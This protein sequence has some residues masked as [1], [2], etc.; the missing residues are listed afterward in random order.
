LKWPRKRK[1]LSLSEAAQASG[2]QGKGSAALLEASN[3]EKRR[4]NLARGGWERKNGVGGVG[5]K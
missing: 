5:E 4:E 1:F 3:A 2:L